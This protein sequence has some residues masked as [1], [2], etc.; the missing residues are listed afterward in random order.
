MAQHSDA[1]VL[2]QIIYKWP[3]ARRVFADGLKQKYLALAATGWAFTPHE[4][5]SV[6]S[7]A[8]RRE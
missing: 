5:Q 6:I 2:G 1:R 7:P 3:Y 4:I 8:F